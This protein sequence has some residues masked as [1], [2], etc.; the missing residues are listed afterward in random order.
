MSYQEREVPREDLEKLL[1][2]LD[3]DEGI[4][5]DVDSYHIFVNKASK[6][7]CINISK[8]NIDE[9]IY[10]SKSSEVV[11]FLDSKTRQSSKFFSY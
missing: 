9:F 7:Y 1:R 4:R 11:D 6:R 10:K 2:T 8:D 5:M 3:S